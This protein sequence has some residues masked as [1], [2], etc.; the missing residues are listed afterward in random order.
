MECR[1]STDK[2]LAGK[3]ILAVDDEKDILG[4][5]SDLLDVCSVETASSFEAA[6]KQLENNY[7]DLAILDIM[8]VDGYSLL[9]IAKGRKIPAIML[10]AHALSADHL[11]KS[12]KEGA[13][14]YAPKEELSNIKSIVAETLEALHSEKSTW[15]KMLERLNDFYDQQFNGHAWM[16]ENEEFWEEKKK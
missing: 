4:T 11:L 9:E 1:M 14:Y 8:G 6:K 2:I 3:R 12:A 10:T 16:D 15:K 5:I 7:Y 13:V